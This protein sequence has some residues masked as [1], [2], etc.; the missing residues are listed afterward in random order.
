MAEERLQ[1]VIAHAGVASRRKA[2]TLITSG[3]VTV[4]GAT[5][6]ELGTK[7]TDEDKVEVDGAPL[8]REMKQYFLLYKPRGVITAVSDPKG[9]KV[10]N[11]F[12]EEIHERLYP[13]GRLDYDT[14]GLIIM[15]NDGD[16]ANMMMHPRYHIDKRYVA[17]VQG[18]PKGVELMPLRDGIT[19]DGRKLA[20]AKAAVVSRD[21]TKQT[22]IVELTIHQGLNHQVKKM[23]K[24]VGFPVLK[25][26]RVGFGFLT[27]DGLQPGDYRKLSH[28]E[29]YQLKEAA[30]LD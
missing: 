20:K 23:L 22:A 16:F 3:H 1:K 10:V 6:T 18:V 7:V 9:R 30:G 13:V 26:S 12:F 25:L 24:A 14:S 29:V 8:I 11:D 5:V 19:I 15:T 27:L 2:E 21:K 17:K 28:N 4:N